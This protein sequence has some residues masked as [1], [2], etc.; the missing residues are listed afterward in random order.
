MVVSDEESL[1]ALLALQ[2]EAARRSRDPGLLA[3]LL[4][5]AERD[6]SSG[7]ARLAWR[8]RHLRTTLDE[9]AT[10]AAGRGYRW[11][12]LEWEHV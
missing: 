9:I 11:H 8:D 2:L 5:I 10:A 3:D 1:R 6:S 4:A 7:L 12:Q